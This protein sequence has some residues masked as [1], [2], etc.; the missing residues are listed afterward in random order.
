M[1]SK[2][3][4]PCLL[5]FLFACSGLK[6]VPAINQG[7]G[8]YVYQLQGNQMPSPGKPASH[9]RG[10]SREIY[11]YEPTSISQTEGSSPVFKAIKTRLVARAKSDS[12][13]HYSVNLAPGKYSVFIKEGQQFFAAESNGDGI[14][15]P[16]TIAPKTITP[17][18]FTITINAVY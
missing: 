11:I 15:N 9:G 6:Q 8:G 5:I 17:K 3:V 10:V 18:N 7:L 4:M 12:L 13:G 1:K 2:Y 16:V 14:L